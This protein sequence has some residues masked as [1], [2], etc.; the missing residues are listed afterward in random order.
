[1]IIVGILII[2]AII[3]YSVCKSKSPKAAF[4][5]KESNDLVGLPIITFYSNK[6]KLH[7]LFDTGADHS[8]FSVN[9]L[10]LIEHQLIDAQGTLTDAGGHTV[11][12]QLAFLKL[13]Y[14]N[15]TFENV[16]QLMDM[17]PIS[18]S[19]GLTV[20]GKEIEIIGIIGVD[21]L[22]K[23]QYIL[24]FSKMIAYSVK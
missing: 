9:H 20:K 8:A 5:F 10:N 11:N 2:C 1:M 21:F 6:H 12:V 19:V 17:T 13:Y 22:T 15:K 14:N 3:C 18:K 7:F 4:S 23:Y 24:D 16:F